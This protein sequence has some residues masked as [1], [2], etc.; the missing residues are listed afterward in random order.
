MRYI[1]SLEQLLLAFRL[2]PYKGVLLANC[3]KQIELR[4]DAQQGKSSNWDHEK[5]ARVLCFI[6]SFIYLSIYKL[7]QKKVT[8]GIVLVLYL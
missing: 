6:K 5:R 1:V 3:H 8:E 2:K 7:G 4:V